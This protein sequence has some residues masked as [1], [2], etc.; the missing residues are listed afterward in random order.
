MTQIVLIKE[1]ASF[2]SQ[3]DE[4]NF[5]RWLQSIPEVK[6]VKGCS[7]GLEVVLEGPISEECLVELM[8]VLSRYS[9]ELQPLKALCEP[10]NEAWFRNPIKYWYP[11][12]FGEE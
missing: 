8:A 7:R 5:F 4:D 1:P 10:N 3:Q 6:A 9:V 11:E 12:I 2:Y